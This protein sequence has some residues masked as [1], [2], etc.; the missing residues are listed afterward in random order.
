[1]ASQDGYAPTIGDRPRSVIRDIV[2]TYE[3][4]QRSVRDGDIGSW[5]GGT[6]RRGL[7]WG[8]G[9]FLLLAT[10]AGPII[11]QQAI[12]KAAWN[13]TWLFVSLWLADWLLWG[14]GLATLGVY[15]RTL[16]R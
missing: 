7:F 12:A 5:I 16:S 13:A 4:Q 8:V 11:Q 10:L 6:S 14:D 1:M 9:G 3:A 15:L 2:I